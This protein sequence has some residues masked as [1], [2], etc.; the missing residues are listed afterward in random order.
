VA[1]ATHIMASAISHECMLLLINKQWA[2]RTLGQFMCR[3]FRDYSRY[4]MQL[5]E[6]DLRQNPDFAVRNYVQLHVSLSHNKNNHM[7]SVSVQL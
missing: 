4:F 2:T 5:V 6:Q 1:I 3:V 7:C